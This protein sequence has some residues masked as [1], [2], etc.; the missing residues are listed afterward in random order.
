MRR[1]ACGLSRGGYWRFRIKDDQE[2]QQTVKG[3][4]DKNR[5]VR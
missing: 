2:K 1:S 5:M 3:Q 4:M